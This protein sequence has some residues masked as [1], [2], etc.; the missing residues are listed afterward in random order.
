MLVLNCWNSLEEK[1]CVIFF[2][3]T[4]FHLHFLSPLVFKMAVIAVG[5]M[6]VLTEL[7]TEPSVH[8]SG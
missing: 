7:T 1:S 3:F 6:D 5:A 4:F 8:P 2:F